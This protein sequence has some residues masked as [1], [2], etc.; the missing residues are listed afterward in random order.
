MAGRRADCNPMYSGRIDSDQGR[1]A[2]RRHKGIMS[3]LVTSKAQLPRT[4]PFA[5]IGDEEGVRRLVEAF[6]N[7]MEQDPAFARLRAIH[8]ADLGPMRARLADFLVQWMGGPRVYAERHPGRPCI[9]SAHS[10]FWIDGAMADDWMACM[11]K[12]FD[13]ARTPEAVRHWVEPVL[14][15]MCQGLR[16][17]RANEGAVG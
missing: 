6:Y 10:P 15:D 1:P 12:A 16:N 3:D 7:I 14:S 2:V 8:A 13:R 4:A 9:V 17:D 11:A 5:L